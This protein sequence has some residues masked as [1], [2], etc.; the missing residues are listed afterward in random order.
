MS[1]SA[2]KTASAIA[3]RMM[4]CSEGEDANK[5]WIP[6]KEAMI[7]AGFPKLAE[8]HY[9]CQNTVTPGCCIIVSN[10]RYEFWK[11][12]ENWEREEQ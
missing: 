6:F 2:K 7:E 8:L 11:V 4:D 5:F 10:A 12:L 1:E 3:K 9:Y